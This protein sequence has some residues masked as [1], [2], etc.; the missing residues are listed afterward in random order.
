MGA[1]PVPDRPNGAFITD[2]L[3]LKQQM[4]M[5]YALRNIRVTLIGASGA[6]QLG[7]NYSPIL[8]TPPTLTLPLAL[9]LN[10]PIPDPTGGATTDTQCRAALVLLLQYLRLTGQLPS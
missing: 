10:A 7:P 9:K 6:N 4:A 1:I 3:Y 2:P 5:L 8:G